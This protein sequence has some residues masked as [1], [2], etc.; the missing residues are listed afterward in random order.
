M[1]EQNAGEV[2]EALARLVDE[3]RPRFVAAAGDVR[4]LQLL[5]DE[6]PKRVQQLLEVVGGELGSIDAV[7][8]AAAG[9]VAATVERD[10][11]ALVERFAAER[12]SG[13]LAADGPGATVAALA[14]SQVDYAARRRR[15]GRRAYRL[16]RRGRGPGRPRSCGGRGDGGGHPGRGTP[17]GRGG[18]RRPRHRCDGPGR[19]RAG[20]GP[21]GAAR[22]PRALL[23]F[24][25]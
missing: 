17:G 24:P 3:V 2:A 22:G 5:R 14:K 13:E 21:P 8:E 23:R 25:G 15:P 19:G 4:A 1:W 9:V 10:T 7:F 16:V 20:S 12:D 18:P 11:G 6:S